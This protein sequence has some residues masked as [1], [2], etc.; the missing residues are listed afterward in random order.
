MFAPNPGQVIQF[1]FGIFFRWVGSTINFSLF[2]T[3]GEHVSFR[4]GIKVMFFRVLSWI[5]P[6]DASGKGR[7]SLESPRTKNLMVT[8]TGG[9][10]PS[11]ALDDLFVRSTLFK[12]GGHARLLPIGKYVDIGLQPQTSLLQKA[13]KQRRTSFFGIHLV[14]LVV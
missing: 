7:F 14:V 12:P 9:V 8:L 13:F 2:V 11:F 4:E 10:N 6:Q 3:A 1:D 5:Y